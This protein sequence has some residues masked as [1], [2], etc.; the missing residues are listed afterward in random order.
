[1][2]L[3]GSEMCIRDRPSFPI[4][5]TSPWFLP[6]G[7]AVAFPVKYRIWFGEPMRFEGRPDDDDAVVEEKV[8]AVRQAMNALLRHGLEQRRGI[9]T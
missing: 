2:G 5:V 8:D 7:V 6:W 9:F 3:V 4:T 1:M